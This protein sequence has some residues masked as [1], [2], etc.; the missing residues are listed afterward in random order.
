MDTDIAEMMHGTETR[1]RSVFGLVGGL[2]GDVRTFMKQE[3]ELVKTEISEKISRTGKNAVSLAI[4]GFVAYAGVIVLLVGLGVVA[5]YGIQSLGLENPWL[6]GFAGLTLVGLLT[7]GLGAIFIM[8]A[9]KAF[10]KT[11]LAPERTMHTLQELRSGHQQ[12]VEPKGHGARPS[13]EE[14]QARVEAT[15]VRMGEKLEELGQRLSPAHINYVVKERLRRQPY[16][17]GAV[18]IGL[19]FFSGFLLRRKLRHA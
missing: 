1:R 19:G 17:F 18:A 7:A 14:V 5:A 9:V 6:A 2:T 3:I 12:P 8:E 11:S 10:S 16:R 4:G 15:E 13:S